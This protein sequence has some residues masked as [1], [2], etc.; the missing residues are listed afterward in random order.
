MWDT[1][2][3]WKL[4]SCFWDEC[5][6]MWSGFGDLTGDIA[7]WVPSSDDIPSVTEEVT[8][9]DD[10]KFALPNCDRLTEIDLSEAT[11]PFGFVPIKRAR[12]GSNEMS[13]S[14]ST[15]RIQRR[16]NGNS[17]EWW[18]ASKQR[19]SDN[20]RDVNTILETEI[21]PESQEVA[22]EGQVETTIDVAENK[23]GSR[24]AQTGT[25]TSPDSAADEAVSRVHFFTATSKNEGLVST[26][27]AARERF[28]RNAY[29]KRA[30]SLPPARPP[31]AHAPLPKKHAIS[32]TQAE[33]L[34]AIF[35]ALLWHEGIV[36]DAIACAAF[37]KFH[38]QLPKQGARVVTRQP[39]DV[40]PPRHQRHSVEVSNAGQYLRIHPSTLES[41]TRSGVEAT[42]SR[43][44]KTDLD[45]PIR[46]EEP[47]ASA[48]A[49]SQAQTSAPTQSA[50]EATG[51]TQSQLE[52]RAPTQSQPGANAMTQ[53]QPHDS[54]STQSKPQ[55]KALA[56][57]KSET[58]SP[59]HSKPQASASA[60]SKLDTSSPAHSKPKDSAPAQS[61]LDTG[62]PAHLKPQTTAPA[63][64]KLDTSSPAHSKPQAAPAQ[65]KPDTSSPAHSKL[66]GPL[67]Q[68]K[69]DPSS[70]AHLKPQ[71]SDS[72][73]SKPESSSPAH[74]KPQ[75][76]APPQSQPQ[77]SALAQAKPKTSATEQA[78][79]HDSA[80][81]QTQ[82]Q[83]GTPVKSQPKDSSMAES[84]HEAST[85][86]Q[87]QPHTS[88]A[89][90]SSTV[91]NVL[92]PAMRALVALWDALYDAD[93]FASVTDKF[94]KDIT[95]RNEN[96]DIR[97][98]SGIRKKRDWK[99]STY[100]KSP[101]SVRC[102]LCA[103]SSVSPPLA[104][105]MRHSHAG[106]RGPTTRGYDRAGV[107][108]R[109]D[110]PAPV[111]TPAT[112]CGQLAQGIHQL[113][114]LYCEKCRDKGLKAASCAKLK[115]KTMSD[116]PYDRIENNMEVDHHV[117]K[118]N[119]LFL[120]ELGPL[121]NS[122]P[123][124]S[125]PWH[126]SAS[127]SPPTPPGSVW[128]PAPPFQCLA[129]LGAAP[130]TNVT[131]T[132]ARYH[133]LGRPPPPPVAPLASVMMLLRL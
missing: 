114:Y 6:G 37:L 38:P 8:C 110:T 46:E 61:K 3:L 77:T 98:T 23:T 48:S 21:V 49:H 81:A 12:T 92:P 54:D 75:T 113:W 39:H 44:R 26:K 47:H 84:Q 123:L 122:E 117:V 5:A 100:Y 82:M 99:T 94:R 15:K 11:F 90:T 29:Y 13:S 66:Q 4:C 50:P 71:A 124:T 133:S 119:A 33:C 43:M 62:S 64:S 56:Q 74:S 105:H 107:Y 103:G 115:S 125:S 34:R 17:E 14:Q 78:Q 118:E 40:Q 121:N 32:P 127:R 58:A 42:T 25:Q 73:Q 128:Q 72:A 45:A 27:T 63:Q 16:S 52:A 76:S 69:P 131:E 88:T 53:S 51:L 95:E 89:S 93:Q 1:I 130:R 106:C 108:R 60:Q 30:A 7:S 111:D 85:F 67:A 31:S 2:S 35:A 132:T 91:V 129:S 65:L 97:S 96:E 20:Y 24:L 83:T 41:L 86:A 109:A 70:S 19:C 116:A 9:A 18:S 28:P 68:S 10:S 120:L 112:A 101:Y 22:E 87:S 57:S 79:P 59:A 102:E 36:H 80:S 104:A 55:A 126:E